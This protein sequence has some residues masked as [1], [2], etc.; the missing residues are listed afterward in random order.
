M[1]W[2]SERQAT[3]EKA[4]ILVKQIEALSMFQTMLCFKLDVSEIPKCMDV[5]AGQKKGKNA[6]RKGT[7]TNIPP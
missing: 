4:K 1:D 7:K 5:V 6:C 3:F 2:G